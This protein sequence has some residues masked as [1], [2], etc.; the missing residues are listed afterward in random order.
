MEYSNGNGKDRPR[1]KRR[2]RNAGQIQC[3]LSNST[4]LV[5]TKTVEDKNVRD[6]EWV[7]EKDHPDFAWI[8]YLNPS[9][10][11]QGSS[12]NPFLGYG[13]LLEVVGHEIER[14]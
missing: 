6:G 10:P 4:N 12:E 5:R 13:D 1:R 11:S 7:D 2:G 8:P 9:S 14:R 3:R